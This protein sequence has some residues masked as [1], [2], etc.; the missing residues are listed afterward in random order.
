MPGE[1]AY[2]AAK[3]AIAGVTRTIADQLADRGI[4]VNAVNPGPVDT[5]YLD[6]DA[7]R[8]LAPM[9][10][11]GRV[12]TPDDAARLVAWLVTDEAAWITGQTLHSEGGFDRG[13]PRGAHHPPLPGSAGRRVEGDALHRPL[14]HRPPRRRRPAR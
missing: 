1:V 5:G 14:A 12:G 9:F 10:P 2:A 8:S 7:R 3:A 4:R 6:E 13:R 11:A